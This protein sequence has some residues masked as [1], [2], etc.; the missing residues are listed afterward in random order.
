MR[1]ASDTSSGTAS[2]KRK[3]T[4]YMASSFGPVRQ[5]ATHPLVDGRFAVLF[6]GRD[7]LDTRGRDVR[8]TRG[9][10][11]RVT[12]QFDRLDE[13][14]F[15]VPEEAL[16]RLVLDF[17]V[18]ED[19]LRG[20]VPVDEALAAID[21]AV[22]EELEERRPDRL[23]ADV[24]HRESGPLPVAR[25]AHRLELAEDRRFVFVLPGLD[26]SDEFLAL[27]VRAAFA[28]LG[29]DAFLDHRLRGDAGVV[30]AGH[31]ERL[32][33]LHPA[34][35]DQDILE[36]VVQG[37]AQVQRRRHVRRR[38]DDRERLALLPSRDGSA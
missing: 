23:G 14:V 5:V 16:D 36:R 3:V 27:E 15:Q 35:T 28:F 2:A 34:K 10:D 31:P 21:Q 32:V 20:R 33:L 30:R 17:V 11:A 7:A 38:D 18:G 24:V 25:A 26:A 9:Q 8:D 6:R 13:R 37:V 22:L 29:E 4:A 1:H 19:G 12:G